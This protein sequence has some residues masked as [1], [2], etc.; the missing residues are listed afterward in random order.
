[1]L[2]GLID[3][4]LLVDAAHVL[5]AY[6]ADVGGG[7]WDGFYQDLHLSAVR[8]AMIAG[9]LEFA[10]ELL[11]SERSFRWH[12]DQRDLLKKLIRKS[13][14]PATDA[15]LVR[16]CH[17]FLDFIRRPHVSQCVSFM[18]L[19]T[20]LEW[21]IIVEKFVNE[22]ELPDWRTVVTQLYR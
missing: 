11:K 12:K 1:M 2:D 8:M 18:S 15:D 21:A 6:C 3:S 20:D 13:V 19:W 17:A 4:V 7:H 16:R 5:E 10:R 9:D 14:R 22:R